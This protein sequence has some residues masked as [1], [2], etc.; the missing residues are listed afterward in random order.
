ML[1][2]SGVN[3]SSPERVYIGPEVQ[4]HLIEPEAVLVQGIIRGKNTIIGAGA[5]IGTS[6]TTVLQDVQVGRDVELGAGS[7]RGATLLD[8]AKVFSSFNTLLTSTEAS[9][10]AS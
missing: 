8:G 7:Y 10:L 6:G 2:S 5:C 1:R 3:V 4:L 9:A